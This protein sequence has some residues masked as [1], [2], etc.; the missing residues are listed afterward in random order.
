M[1]ERRDS[2]IALGQVDFLLTRGLGQ[3]GGW[4]FVVSCFVG[5]L[6][7]IELTLPRL[8]V[9]L[10]LSSVCGILWGFAMWRFVVRPPKSPPQQASL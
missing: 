7:G 2:L 4:F 6:N 10:A 3:F 8:S 9:N 1:G 5:V